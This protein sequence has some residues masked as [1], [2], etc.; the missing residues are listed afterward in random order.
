MAPVTWWSGLFAPVTQDRRVVRRVEVG[1]ALEHPA[2]SE[3]APFEAEELDDA[4]DAGSP[5]RVVLHQRLGHGAAVEPR[6]AGAG[7]LDVGGVIARFAPAPHVVVL[8]DRRG[9]HELVVDLAADGT[10][11]AS[12]GTAATPQRSKMRRYASYISW[13]DACMP[14]GEAS[15]E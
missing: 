3:L 2:P 8:T 6:R 5:R 7:G 13:Y 9:D 4:V 1:D 14:A 15:K 11:S 10:D 12:T